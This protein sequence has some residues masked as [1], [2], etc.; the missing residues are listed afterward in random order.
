[1][2]ACGN[3]LLMDVSHYNLSVLSMSVIGF[4]IK[5]GRGGWWVG[6]LYPVF[7]GLLKCVKLVKQHIAW[8]IG[9]MA[10]KDAPRLTRV[11]VYCS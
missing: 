9:P 5:L 4:K 2:F 7:F 10:A 8:Y 6:E 3:T 11:R 1:M